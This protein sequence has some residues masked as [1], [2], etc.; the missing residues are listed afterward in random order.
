[1]H[2]RAKPWRWIGIVCLCALAILTGHS[3]L[4]AQSAPPSNT[5]NTR[6]T[7][8]AA[9]PP[10][11]PTAPTAIP[12]HRQADRVA[13]LTVYGEID[14]MTLQS[15]ERRVE[16]AREEGF[17]AIVF[18]IDTPGGRVDAARDIT[19]L[20]KNDA[21]ANTVAWIH[22]DAFSAGT[23]IALSCDEIVVSRDAV[24]GDC[25][26]IAI[27]PAGLVA[28]PPAER[29]KLEAPLRNNVIDSA[30]RH[31]YDERLAESFIAVGVE[32]WM[33][34]NVKTGDRVFVD[35]KEYNSIFN[36]DPPENITNV[37]PSN[38]QPKYGPINPYF[39]DRLSDLFGL[40]KSDLDD[41][42]P[43]TEEEQQKLEEE[44]QQAQRLPSSRKLLTAA[45]APDWQ[46]VTQVISDNKLLV[47]NA[48]ESID[49][50]LGQAIIDND[51][52][53]KAY[54]G[55]KE[56]V[57][58][59]ES[60]SEKLVRLLVNDWVRIVLIVVF[61][62]CLLIEM[63]LP[64]TGV[65]GVGAALALLVLIGAPF[66]VGMAQWWEILLILIGIGL[67][68]VEI[69]VIPGF[70]I[71][72]IAG[73]IALLVGVVGTFVSGDISSVEGQNELYT[74]IG[75]TLIGII[76]AAIGVWLLSR[77][78]YEMPI[79]KRLILTATTDAN[80][81]TDGPPPGMLESLAKRN[82]REVTTGDIGTA[83]TDLR[84]SGRAI[85]DGRAVDVV[86]VGS[87]IA[88]GSQVT[89]VNVGQFRVEVDV[90][91]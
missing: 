55:A 72:G 22:P 5:P 33:L 1:M 77:H 17:D 86:S 56:V 47:V 25:A 36:D 24:W 74:G 8:N 67:I 16:E 78:L 73:V 83:D 64:G 39:D 51:Q 75:A 3:S 81:S 7:P 18:E 76:G 90:V 79:F 80:S 15:L 46:V 48:A 14:L 2:N 82:D 63:A 43:L 45:D 34:E 6:N 50:G 61:I 23:L 13:V 89:V 58:I 29:A 84:P 88:A 4:I 91:E 31:G 38:S 59:D 87:Y 44:I 30:R 66:L 10:T 70:G 68:C 27:G 62:L 35:R 65:F 9:A 12:A 85:F 49:F 57:R 19:H 28:L 32:L 40:P 41:D 11:H 20:I 71:P 52:E 37:T 26:P 53:L 69:F 42:T 60:W 54:F 21:G